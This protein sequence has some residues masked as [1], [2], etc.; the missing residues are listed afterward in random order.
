MKQTFFV[1]N[2]DS[3]L[4]NEVFTSLNYRRILHI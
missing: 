1:K 2:F 4:Q 3:V